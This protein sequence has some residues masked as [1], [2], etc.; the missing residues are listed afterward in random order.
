MFSTPDGDSS[1]FN[2]ADAPSFLW[3]LPWLFLLMLFVCLFVRLLVCL[4]VL[5]ETLDNVGDVSCMQGVWNRF[6]RLACQEKVIE[7]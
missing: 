6:H 5:N 1:S 3:V 7:L 2:L 4:F